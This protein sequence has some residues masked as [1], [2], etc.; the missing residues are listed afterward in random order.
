MANKVIELKVR[1]DLDVLVGR[2][3]GEKLY[4]E[5][6]KEPIDVDDIVTFIF[7]KTI[8]NF[9]ASFVQGLLAEI[10][11]IKGKAKAIEDVK[12]V[13]ENPDLEKEFYKKFY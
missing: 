12:I 4:S 10:F 8:N 11:M 7:P 2:K 6:L 13:T 1:N 9:T 5:N 3:L